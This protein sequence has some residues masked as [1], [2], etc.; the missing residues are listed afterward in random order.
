[1]DLEGARIAVSVGPGALISVS[2]DGDGWG[3]YDTS[4]PFAAF[5][6]GNAVSSGTD[7]GRSIVKQAVEVA[8]TNF[9]NAT[10]T[11]VNNVAA[12]T[13]AATKRAAK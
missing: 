7:L 9:A 12:A 13:K 10:T 3:S 8:E 5:N 1:M 4:Q 6:R 2:D 11:A